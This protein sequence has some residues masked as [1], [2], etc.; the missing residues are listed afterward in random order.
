MK[1]SKKY[2]LVFADP[3][4]L[5]YDLTKITETILEQ[6]NKK[7]KFYLECEKNQ[8]SFMD[9]VVRDYGRT[10]ILYWENI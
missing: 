6:L 2:D 8:S 9:G 1:K 4:Y 10:R 5:K 3:P 7:G